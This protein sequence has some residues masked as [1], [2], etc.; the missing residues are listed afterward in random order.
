MLSNLPYRSKFEPFCMIP[1]LVLVR[2]EEKDSTDYFSIHGSVYFVY[3][4]LPLQEVCYIEFE[5]SP[6]LIHMC[7]CFWVR[8]VKERLL[9]PE[10][11]PPLMRL[12]ME[13]LRKR[14]RGVGILLRHARRLHRTGGMH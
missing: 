12:L 5:P 3:H 11:N 13:K 7:F 9:R 14:P 4:F 1:P 8:D 10:K 2:G 6:S